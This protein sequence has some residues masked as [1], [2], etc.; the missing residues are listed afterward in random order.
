MNARIFTITGRGLQP[1]IVK[2]YALGRTVHYTGDMANASGVGAIVAIRQA[3]QY[4]ALPPQLPWRSV[5]GSS[6]QCDSE[7]SRTA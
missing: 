1:L 5:A 2:D 4:P 6:L 3:T 7:D